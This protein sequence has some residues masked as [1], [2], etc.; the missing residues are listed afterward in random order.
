MILIEFGGGANL[1]G[2]ESQMRRMS[3]Y[4]VL[5][6]ER[7]TTIND[8]S[9]GKIIWHIKLL[10]FAIKLMKIPVAGGIIRREVE[11][12]IKR[13]RNRYMLASMETLE[14]LIE[15]SIEIAI[16]PRICLDVH[17]D[18]EHPSR[19]VFLDELADALVKAGKAEKATKG[20][21]LR[22]L[23]EGRLNGHS[24]IVSDVS[25]KPMELCNSCKDC[26]ILWKLENSGVRCIVNFI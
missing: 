24:C 16:G 25:G 22:T 3:D 17:K 6:D 23:R 12:G 18:C 5:W 21:A 2:T 1:Q 15:N 13:K 4:G 10:D 20:D 7:M 14:E 19:S 8:Y 26:C 9:N 11:R